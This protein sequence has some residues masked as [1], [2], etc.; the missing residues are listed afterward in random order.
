MWQQHQ[1][2]CIAFACP[3]IRL[4]GDTS[5]PAAK[6]AP[7]FSVTSGGWLVDHG[8]AMPIKTPRDRERLLAIVGIDS[9]SVRR[10]AR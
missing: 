3:H 5:S 9:F 7:D 2:L 4:D 6:M 8:A 10:A 1:H